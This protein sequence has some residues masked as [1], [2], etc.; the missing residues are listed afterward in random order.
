[1]DPKVISVGTFESA[2]E[3]TTAQALLEVNGIPSVLVNAEAAQVFGPPNLP[4]LD[5]I[6]IEVQEEHRVEAERLLAKLRAARSAPRAGSAS[7]AAP[8]ICLECGAT[9]DLRDDHC[10]TCGWSWVG[11]E[12]TLYENGPVPDS[13]L[14]Y[15]HSPRDSR[16]FA[17]PVD[18][19]RRYVH[20]CRANGLEIHGWEVWVPEMAT[21]R[22]V[23]I[24]ERGDGEALLAAIPAA[25]EEHGE[26]AL[27]C[28]YV[29]AAPAADE[30]KARE[31]KPREAEME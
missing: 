16:R 2:W 26:R 25:V 24:H 1:M 28:A 29:S 23:E 7:I 8:E 3:A 20:W 6:A 30:R 4:F 17:L 15:V 10:S 11:E 27:F 14:G 19:A 21:H 12:T 13:L 9:M 22:V 18:A 31:E 5:A